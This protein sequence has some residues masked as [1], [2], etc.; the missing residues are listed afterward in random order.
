MTALLKSTSWKKDVLL[1][2]AVAS[3]CAWPG[4]LCGGPTGGDVVGLDLSGGGYSGNVPAI[5]GARLTHL[6]YVDLSNNKLS[7][8]LPS[9]LLSLASLRLLVFS[10][11]AGLIADALP[12]ALQLGSA[13]FPR[14]NRTTAFRYC[15]ARRTSSAPAR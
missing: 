11:N 1:C 7:G 10:G 8:K 2:G 5:V 3:Y 14:G 15:A 4:V 6:T 13:H 9:T 12:E